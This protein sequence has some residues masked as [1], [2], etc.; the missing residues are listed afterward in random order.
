MKEM[1][2]R[3]RDVLEG[4]LREDGWSRQTEAMK[5]EAKRWNSLGKK[6]QELELLAEEWGV[7]TSFA[8]VI[9]RQGHKPTPRT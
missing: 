8:R 2:K 7:P 9:Q 3:G 6:E 4:A 1:I 5:A